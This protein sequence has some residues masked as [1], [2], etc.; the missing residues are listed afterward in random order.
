MDQ[1]KMNEICYRIKSLRIKSRMSQEDL[2]EKSG[3]PYT[4]LMRI[5]MGAENPSIFMITKIAEILG[6]TLEEIMK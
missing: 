5:E 1:R 4:T 3:I 6:T 2:A